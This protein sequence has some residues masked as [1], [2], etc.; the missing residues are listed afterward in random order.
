M[1]RPFETGLEVLARARARA[2]EDLVALT[3]R[4][5]SPARVQGCRF[6]PG[7]RARDLVTGQEVEVVASRFARRVVAPAGD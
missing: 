1:P 7:D 2:A 5:T 4:E 6:V 3:G